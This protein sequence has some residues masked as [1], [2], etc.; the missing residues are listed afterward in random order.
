[1]KA[2]IYLIYYLKMLENVFLSITLKKIFYLITF[3]EKH[4]SLV[5]LEKKT[6]Y[7]VNDKKMFL[8][9]M[10]LTHCLI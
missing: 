6:T 3:V 1:M 5:R 7:P 4:H 2:F 10:S 8:L 9:E